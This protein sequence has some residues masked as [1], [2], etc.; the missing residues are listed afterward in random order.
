MA[1]RPNVVFL[2]SDQH[3]A[4]GFGHAGDPVLQTPH[5]DQ[6]AEDGVRFT[7]AYTT[8]PVCVP[9][10]ASLFTAS[11]PHNTGVLDNSAYLPDDHR[12]W[13]EELRDGGYYTALVGEAHQRRPEH[14]R[15]NEE[16]YLPALGF[17]YIH[18]IGGDWNERYHE[19]YLTDEWQENGLYDVFKDD[20]DARMEVAESDSAREAV[21]K[22]TWASPLPVEDHMDSYVGRQATQFLENYDRDDPFCLYVGFSGPHGPMDPPGEYAELYDP[23]EMPAPLPDGGHDEWV[24]SPAA[25][26]LDS[27]GWNPEY[28]TEE[29]AREYRAAY[30][31]KISLIDHW[32]GEII[33]AL[34]DQG[35]LENTLVMYSA[36]HGEFA[37]DRGRFGKSTFHEQSVNIPL[38]V[39]W[40]SE[41][42]AGASCDAP[43]ELVDIGGTAVDA[44]G[45]SSGQD[46]PTSETFGFGRSVLAAARTPGNPEAAPREAAH[47]IHD[48]RTMIRTRQYK[49]AIDEGGRGYLLY[50][51]SS[52]PDEQRN[53]VGHPDYAGVE[54]EHRDRLLGF[55]QRTSTNYTRSGDQYRVR[56]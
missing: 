31:G 38:L 2:F 21:D 27:L 10:R 41:L 16:S 19:S 5:F 56:G 11:Y 49:Y 1:N 3:R 20:L 7:N 15:E 47:S 48:T 42:S 51:L 35:E 50:D 33:D 30:Y 53:L 6:I 22:A 25:D 23:A 55:L 26:Y 18:E 52:D 45:M 54:R 9:A 29:M 17:E 39:R 37:G 4:D 12:T 44:A 43:V 36:D 34:A 14:Y 46:D 32:V 28:W 8:C 13:I 40:P 24:P